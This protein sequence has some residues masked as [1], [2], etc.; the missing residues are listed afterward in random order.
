MLIIRSTGHWKLI[1]ALLYKNQGYVGI[2]IKF[3]FP[4][5]KLLRYWQDVSKCKRKIFNYSLRN[6]LKK[7]YVMYV[8]FYI[9]INWNFILLKVMANT[10]EVFK[11]KFLHLKKKKKLLQNYFFYRW[12]KTCGTNWILFRKIIRKR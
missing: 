9:A 10:F 4:W 12:Y 6:L 7:E 1:M 2:Y 3:F 11:C 5:K 8:Y